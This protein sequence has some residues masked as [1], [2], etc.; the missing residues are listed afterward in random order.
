MSAHPPA[1]I[2]QT[3]DSRLARRQALLSCAIIRNIA[4]YYAGW[5]SEDGRGQLKDDTELGRTINSNFIDMAVLEWA[6]LFVEARGRHHWYRFVRSVEARTAFR[7]G[8]L[9]G[10]GLDLPAWEQR[11]VLVAAQPVLMPRM[12]CPVGCRRKQRSALQ[13]L[14]LP[15]KNIATLLLA[16]RAVDSSDG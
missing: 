14:R 3:P 1:A 6:K 5:V 8:L 11:A 2:P 10:I 16:V 12:I 7:T 9:A 15:H 13:L 4:F